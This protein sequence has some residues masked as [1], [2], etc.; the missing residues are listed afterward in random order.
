VLAATERYYREDCSNVHRGVYGLAARA[1]AAYEAVRGTAR[2][3]LGAACDDEIVFTRGTTEAM[4]LVARCF[5]RPRLLARRHGDAVLV[6][7][8]E[9]HSNIVPWQLLTEEVG[10]RLLV[11]PIDDRGELILEE[12]E[13]LLGE[14]V[15]IAAFPHVSNALGTVN[16]VAT[17]V[18]LA[19]SRGVP[20]AIDG[21]QAAPHLPIDI[22]PLG[23]DF[24]AFSGHKVFGPT[25]IGVLWGRG[26]LLAAMPPYEGGGDMIRSVSFAKTT[27]ADPPVRFE[28]GTPNVAG[29][30]GLGAALSYVL[31]VGREAIAAHEQEL[32][33]HATEALLAIPG[34]RLI[35]TA[36][37]KAC[38][39]SFVMEGVHPHDIGTIL[40]H[41][42]VAVRA[43]HHCAQPVMDRF[44][45][46]ATARASFALYNTHEE[47]ERL[48]AALLQV[49]EMFS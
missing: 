18:A 29:A 19:R 33:A 3:F 46:P 47:V 1:T 7:H 13:R 35:G 26:E 40:D 34:L 32:L 20:V 16:P 49:R 42:G 43:G 6:T 4:N 23:S 22:G 14:G 21:A 5:A 15:A 37:E 48:A 9:H 27:Y 17:M 28:A 11:A 44:G 25:G 12:F 39:L 8:M 45:V 38:V 24:Y 2:R 41:A 30:I 31:E 10:G 36:R